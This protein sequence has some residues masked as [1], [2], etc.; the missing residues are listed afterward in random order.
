MSLFLDEIGPKKYEIQ[1]F[2]FLF[3]NKAG[4]ILLGAEQQ[5]RAGTSFI[6]LPCPSPPWFHH[7]RVAGL[8]LLLLSVLP[9]IFQ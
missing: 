5:L 6:T 7:C 1:F 2:L 3:L 4:V 8:L 9:F